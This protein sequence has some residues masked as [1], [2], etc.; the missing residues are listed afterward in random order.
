MYK[1]MFTPSGRKMKESNNKI[2]FSVRSI[3]NMVTSYQ[4]GSWQIIPTQTSAENVHGCRLSAKQS[5]NSY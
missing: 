4:R 3:L 5:D 2:T 1:K